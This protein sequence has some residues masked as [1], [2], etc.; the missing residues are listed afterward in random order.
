VVFP[1]FFIDFLSDEGDVVL[2]PFAG[3]NSTGQA[4]EM[5]KRRWL[6][7]EID[8]TYLKGS[9]YRFQEVN[10]IFPLRSNDAP[11]IQETTPDEGTTA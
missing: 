8:E 10:D 4:A 7:F 6:A 5:A 9:M 11:T 3:S 2:D 1:R